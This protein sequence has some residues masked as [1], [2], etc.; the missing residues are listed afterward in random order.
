MLDIQRHINCPI[1]TDAVQPTE[2]PYDESQQWTGLKYACQKVLEIYY[3]V[4]DKQELYDLIVRYI[5]QWNSQI[6]IIHTYRYAYKPNHISST[7][8]FLFI[9]SYSLKTHILLFSYV[10]CLF[11][12]LFCK[13]RAKM[14]PMIPK[15]LT[16][17]PYETHKFNLI[18]MVN[19]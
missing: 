13:F 19:V 5:I 4:F 14:L 9:K 18:L 3:K 6:H 10:Q 1:W 17:V 2:S 11:L 8:T 7:T 12:C 16:V 15:F